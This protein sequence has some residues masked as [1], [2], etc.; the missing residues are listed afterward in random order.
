[1]ISFGFGHSLPRHCGIGTVI[2]YIRANGRLLDAQDLTVYQ[3]KRVVNMGTQPLSWPSCRTI[4]HECLERGWGR[5]DVSM[6]ED[7]LTWVR[8]AT[9]SMGLR[10][11]IRHTTHDSGRL[12]AEDIIQWKYKCI[13][14]RS[15]FEYNDGLIITPCSNCLYCYRV[16][17][18]CLCFATKLNGWHIFWSLVL[19]SS[20]WRTSKVYIC[21]HKVARNSRKTEKK[22]LAICMS[23]G[24]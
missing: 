18:R 14:W 7:T 8:A 24:L 6:M 19:I 3:C 17:S 1:M 9:S 16:L 23:V 21:I 12:N 5:W 11:D 4:H 13:D 20:I 15:V 2:V 22:Q 10:S